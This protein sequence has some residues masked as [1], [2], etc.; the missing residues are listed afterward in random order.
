MSH[1]Q[2]YVCLK[3]RSTTAGDYC[4]SCGAPLQ[5]EFKD[6]PQLAAQHFVME[7]YDLITKEAVGR[8][9]PRHG[10]VL[11]RVLERIQPLP[12][13]ALISD[14]SPPDALRAVIILPQLRTTFE[15]GESRRLLNGLA[16]AVREESA[17]DKIRLDLHIP[18]FI[19][20]AEVGEVQK[21]IAASTRQRIKRGRVASVKL[22]P[23]DVGT[24]KVFA[25][26]S[27]PERR[28]LVESLRQL[29]GSNNAQRRKPNSPLGAALAWLLL[30]TLRAYLE[31]FSKL[32]R[33]GSLARLIRSGNLDPH[34]FAQ[35][36]L[37]ALGLTLLLSTLAGLQGRLGVYPEGPGLAT[38][39][40]AI[41]KLSL[42][43]VLGY[44]TWF[45]ALAAM[46]HLVL[47]LLG[48]YG[49]LNHALL[50][51]L[52]VGAQGLPLTC[53]AL[54]VTTAV[55]P[56]HTGDVL[57]LGASLWTGLAVYLLGNLYELSA[58]YLWLCVC[59]FALPF[60]IALAVHQTRPAP[61]PVVQCSECTEVG[62]PCTVSHP[63]RTGRGLL[64]CW[65]L[66]MHCSKGI[67]RIDS[68]HCARVSASAS[69][70]AWTPW[71]HFDN[72]KH[73]HHL[74]ATTPEVGRVFYPEL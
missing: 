15:A 3:C 23:V 62:C 61:A 40:Q 57:L 34:R 1:A 45:S 46:C 53:L 6:L 51:A 22:V 8:Q 60:L 56:Q 29:R 32:A 58:R 54:T 16:Q 31:G 38:W 5:V 44:F 30:E 43:Y 2:K 68:V 72:R 24:R 41:D 33:I 27:A 4:R 17:P 50:A 64:V 49:K 14:A 63:R 59:G 36:L 52:F 70:L 21:L 39:V 7:G 12:S 9:N 10:D 55:A 13:P 74:S 71:A 28:P 69:V 67:R 47:T 65:E 48:G 73:C 19:E 11:Q 42:G 20:S 66:I 37:G 18:I 35:L 25:R 26:F